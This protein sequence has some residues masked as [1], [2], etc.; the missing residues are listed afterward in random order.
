MDDKN[1]QFDKWH[2]I[3]RKK[4]D[5]HPVVDEFKCIGCELCTTTRGRSVYKFDY[6]KKSKAV[7]S[8]NCMVACQT[9]AN[10]CLAGAISLLGVFRVVGWKIVLNYA[11]MMLVFGIIGG[12]VFAYLVPQIKLF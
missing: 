7:N 10:L 2:G 12:P 8:Y 4:I 3:D 9:C 5:W 11:L 6:E 1:Y